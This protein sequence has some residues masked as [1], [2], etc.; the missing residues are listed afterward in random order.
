MDLKDKHL[1]T[2]FQNGYSAK[3]YV[4][5]GVLHKTWPKTNEN[6]FSDYILLSYSELKDPTSNLRQIV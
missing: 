2:W 6:S 5:T 4:I 1:G 3:F